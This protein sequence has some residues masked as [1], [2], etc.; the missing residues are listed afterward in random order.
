M[1]PVSVSVNKKSGN[2]RPPRVLKQNAD[3]TT[4]AVT[5][6]PAQFNMEPL[7]R[8]RKRGES[9]LVV[10]KSLPGVEL[11]LLLQGVGKS[12]G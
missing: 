12:E 3:I 7:T 9:R 4:A 8:N 1:E 5:M 2:I 11:S 10:A 6:T